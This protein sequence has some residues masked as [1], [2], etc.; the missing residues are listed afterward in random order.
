[1]CSSDLDEWLARRDPS[2]EEVPEAGTVTIRPGPDPHLLVVWN[3]GYA[4]P[5]LP[6][7]RIEQG[8]SP[9][10]AA[11]RETAEETGVKVRLL[12]TRPVEVTGVAVEHRPWLRRR[13]LFFPAEPSGNVPESALRSFRC[14]PKDGRAGLAGS[15]AASSWLPLSQA[16]L[17]FRQPEC[18]AALVRLSEKAADI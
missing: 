13:I 6:K 12:T 14:P 17:A 10:E 15:I 16:Q 18:L 8:E 3:V 2:V 5:S 7:G 4:D 1:V 11:V 9:A